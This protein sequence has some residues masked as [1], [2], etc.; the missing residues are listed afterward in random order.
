VERLDNELRRETIRAEELASDLS[1]LR[2][3]TV[4][5]GRERD[6]EAKVDRIQREADNNYKKLQVNDFM[7]LKREFSKL[8]PR[9][10]VLLSYVVFY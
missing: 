4:S 8:I 7:W 1:A 3:S 2:Q 5:V 10:R 9:S 6:L